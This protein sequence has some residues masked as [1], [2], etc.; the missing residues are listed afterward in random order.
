MF[1]VMVKKDE[2]DPAGK[3]KVE[4]ESAK[5]AKTTMKQRYEDISEAIADGWSVS[6]RVLEE[7]SR[8]HF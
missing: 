3:I 1:F 7:Y 5:E 4:D 2:V 8:L 6:F